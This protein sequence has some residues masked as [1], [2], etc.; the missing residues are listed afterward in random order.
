MTLWFSAWVIA[1]AVPVFNHLLSL[2]S[3]LFA[4]WFTYGVSG[5]F[6]LFLNQGRYGESKGKMVMTGVNVGCFFLGGV[7]VS[8]DDSSP[9]FYISI[10]PLSLYLICAYPN[11]SQLLLPIHPTQFKLT[12][13]SPVRSRPLQ[14]RHRHQQRRSYEFKSQLFLRRQ[15]ELRAFLLL[16]IMIEMGL[17]Y[18]I[19]L[20]IQLDAF[21]P[22][23]AVA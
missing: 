20:D 19:T 15:F 9:S 6:W 23:L 4:S 16:Q 3:A 12:T 14:L 7:I 1:E 22:S 2:I 5:V 11:P 17:R 13:S 18:S 8:C 21:F 10:S